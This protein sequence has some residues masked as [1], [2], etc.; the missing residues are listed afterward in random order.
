M[1][2]PGQYWVVHGALVYTLSMNF[3]LDF[4]QNWKVLILFC[5]FPDLIGTVS[6]RSIPFNLDGK[7]HYKPSESQ[8][9]KMLSQKQ[10]LVI[11]L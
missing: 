3:T 2:K 8:I 1:I 10:P 7:A 9:D 5:Y 6:D 4:G 11:L